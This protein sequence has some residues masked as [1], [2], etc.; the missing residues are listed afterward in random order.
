M[1]NTNHLKSLLKKDFLTLFRSKGYLA[2]FVLLPILL[3]WA[4][5]G[6]TKLVEDEKDG[7]GLRGG[8]MVQ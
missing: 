3:M 7:D 2:A 6:I 8:D 1:M 4:Q 5:G